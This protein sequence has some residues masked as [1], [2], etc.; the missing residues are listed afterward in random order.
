VA[1]L[2]EKIPP[3]YLETIRQD[4]ETDPIPLGAGGA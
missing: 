1:G 4:T 3:P 2:K